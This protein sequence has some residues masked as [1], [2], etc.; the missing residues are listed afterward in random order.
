MTSYDWALLLHLLAAIAFFSGLAIAAVAQLG[1]LRR[2]RAGEV[3][4]V[5]S[6]ARTGVVALAGG[7]VLVLV[8]GLWLIEETNRS[9]GDGWVAASLVLLLVSL[10]LGGAGGRRARQARV[11]A[12]S[13][14][15]GA[16]VDDAI[17]R[18]LHDRASLAANLL[19]S[20]AAIGVVVLMVW[21]PE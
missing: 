21:R 4:A 10:L 14:E 17:R 3:A 2:D 6:L 19:A 12:A 1:A 15:P 20:A 8:S 16:P 7:L 5:L 9:L 11:L 18:L 13:R